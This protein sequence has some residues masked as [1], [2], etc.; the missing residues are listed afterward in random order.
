MFTAFCIS[1]AI[2]EVTIWSIEYAEDEDQVFLSIQT[3]NQRSSDKYP[4]FSIC[5]QGAAFHWYRDIDI[6]NAHAVDAYQYEQLLKGETAIMYEFNQSSSLYDKV[7]VSV[8]NDSN[9]KFDQFHVQM[10]D[11]LRELK[12]TTT[13]ARHTSYYSNESNTKLDK[14]IH[15]S[16]QSPEKI[17]FSRNDDDT[18]S[19]VRLY[20]LVTLDSSLIELMMYRHTTEMQ[21]FIHYP[22]HLVTSF[23]KPKY[24]ATFDYL[25]YK[26]RDYDYDKDIDTH[27]ILEFKI[28]Q[29]K[30]LKKRHK[31]SSPCNT[32]IKNYDKYLQLQVVNQL[33]CVPVYWKET[34][35]K[36]TNLTECTS[37][38]KLKQAFANIT[39]ITT[40]ISQNEEPCKEMFLLSIDSINNKPDPIPKD[41]AIAFYYTE[42]IYEEITYSKATPFENWLSNVGGFVG[43]FLG[44]SMM[45][46]PAFII[47]IYDWFHDKKYRNM[48]GTKNIYTRY[49]NIPVRLTKY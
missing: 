22:N 25:L 45:Q 34:L 38:E 3:Y 9:T 4:T 39:D 30:V 6:F 47:Q 33:E 21:I 49:I 23:D 28:S 10:E 40:L 7:P 12:Y 11:V 36:D 24:I 46:I 37:A 42:K 48:A 18:L 17:C 41:I 35:Q 16:F 1:M 44:Y 43:I 15:L 27:N 5:F 19:S 31:T 8:N 2:Y 32:E 14:H 20:D 13:E 29:S 26:L